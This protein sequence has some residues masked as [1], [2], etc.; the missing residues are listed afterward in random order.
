MSFVGRLADLDSPFFG[1]PA[2]GWAVLPDGAG[3]PSACGGR[4]ALSVAAAGARLPWFRG[5]SVGALAAAESRC[6]LGFEAGSGG[7]AAAT[8]PFA[9]DAR[10]AGVCC[11]SELT[12]VRSALG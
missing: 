10:G 1:T 5:G 4:A 8:V 2:A 11:L 9:S 3:T 6:E 12:S 7:L